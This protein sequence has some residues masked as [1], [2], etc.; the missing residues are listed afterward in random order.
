MSDTARHG[1]SIL[2]FISLVPIL[3]AATTAKAR[4][5]LINRLKGAGALDPAHAIALD[6]L[7]RTERSTLRRLEA[8]N[9]VRVVDGR[10]YY[11]A[12]TVASRRT[13]QR[14]LMWLLLVALAVAGL[15]LGIMLILR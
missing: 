10:Y 13:A 5:K 3:I 4:E 7:S 2:P 11:D 12:A 14:P 15:A 1:T 8:A 9:T 6:P